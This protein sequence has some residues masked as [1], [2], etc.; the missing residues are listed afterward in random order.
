MN[1]NHVI[2]QF[3]SGVSAD[4][5]GV[6][7]LAWEKMA[8][9]MGFKVELFKETAADDSKLRRTMTIEERARL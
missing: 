5:Q 1:P 6:L 2:V 4:D 3:G 7:L 9:G 8:R